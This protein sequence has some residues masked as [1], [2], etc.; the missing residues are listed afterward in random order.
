[1]RGSVGYAMTFRLVVEATAEEA[2][3]DAGLGDDVSAGTTLELLAEPT[4]VDVQGVRLGRIAGAPD[5]LGDHAIGEHL[6][7]MRREQLDQVPLSRCEV[8]LRAFGNK[9]A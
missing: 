3:A 8:D 4:N 5:C 1:M 9:A 6:I 7:R 2:V